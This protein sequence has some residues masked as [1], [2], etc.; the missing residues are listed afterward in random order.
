MPKLF[1]IDELMLLI[2]SYLPVRILCKTM[3]TCKRWRKLAQHQ[4]NQLGQQVSFAK[5]I[6]KFN[7]K[8]YTEIGGSDTCISFFITKKNENAP[9]TSR[10]FHDYC[11][12][13]DKILVMSL[14]IGGLDAT[15]SMHRSGKFHKS[16][17]F[18]MFYAAEH[19]RVPEPTFQLTNNAAKYRN[20]IVCDREFTLAD[21][22]M[23]GQTDRII[24]SC[25]GCVMHWN[26][27]KV[28]VVGV[29]GRDIC[30]L[31]M[32]YVIPFLKGRYP[33]VNFDRFRPDRPR[34]PKSKCT[35]Q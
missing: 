8:I 13:L 18:A 14:K 11:Q 17:D 29:S 3:R 19:G 1:D 33:M 25:D 27:G 32:G 12:S 10:S 31:F 7:V 2:M 22:D 24:F 26:G 34:K 4:I 15:V 30:G 9:L 28:H 20:L 5:H 21:F 35:V 23:V 6:R 16:D